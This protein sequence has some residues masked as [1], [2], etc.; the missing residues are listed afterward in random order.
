MLGKLI[1][2]PAVKEALRKLAPRSFQIPPYLAAPP[3]YK[4][5]ASAAI[6][7]RAFDY[8]M[9][10][11]ISRQY[12]ER[13]VHLPWI[14]EEAADASGQVSL[15][16]RKTRPITLSAFDLP[17]R[18]KRS[19][20]AT[21]IVVNHY[22]KIRKADAYQKLQIVEHALR[23]A[24]V[25]IMYRWGSGI[26]DHL[27]ATPTPDEIEDTLSM[28][29]VVPWDEI[30]NL[31][32]G[33]ILPGPTFGRAGGMV[34][35]ADADLIVGDA[36][37]DISTSKKNAFDT[38]RFNNVIAYYIIALVA[39]ALGEDL[40]VINKLCTYHAR[41]VHIHT[42]P[43]RKLHEHPSWNEALLTFLDSTELQKMLLQ[44][45]EDN[46]GKTRRATQLSGLYSMLAELQPHRGE[47]LLP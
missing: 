4:D 47:R 15:I 22:Q 17:P 6:I 3:L 2:Q 11:E 36:L 8:I 40:P 26:A 9:K 5:I 43:A 24:R 38:E 37:V 41:H 45:A 25:E 18:I 20:H 27:S 30:S 13:A 44:E 39:R 12:P 21:R 28:L 35:G 29:R 10:W 33:P 31:G 34:G 7:G 32:E 42:I 16:S 14:L 1:E 46:F 23:L 19:V